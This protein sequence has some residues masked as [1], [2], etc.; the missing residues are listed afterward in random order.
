MPGQEWE[1]AVDVVVRGGP[2][3]REAVV[4]PRGIARLGEEGFELMHTL[5]HIALELA[6]LTDSLEVTVDSARA[7]GMS[8]ASIGFCVGTT[9]EAARQRWG[10]L[11]G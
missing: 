4:V 1:G 8:W 9:G 6:R 10:D 7:R 11:D 3:G 2:A 5:Q